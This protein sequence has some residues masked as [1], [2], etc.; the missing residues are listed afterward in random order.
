M[1][2]LIV[3]GILAV[4]LIG[5]GTA[6]YFTQ[7]S[8]TQNTAQETPTTTTSG[9]TTT[10]QPG[11]GT[12]SSTTT[13]TSGEAVDITGAWYGTYTSSQGTGR[14]AWRIWKTGENTYQGVLRTTDPYST[15]TSAVPITIQLNGKQITVGSVAL[16]VTFTGT[17][18]GDAMSGTWQ[19]NN[20]M[21]GGQWSGQRGE[22]DI[23]PEQP[24]TTTPSETTTTTP[25]TGGEYNYDDISEVAPPSTEPYRTITIDLRDTFTQ[26]QG[27]AKL[28]GY[29]QS[30]A[31]GIGH[32][33]LKNPVT[34]ANSTATQIVDILVGK[35]YIEPYP[36]TPV[37][38]TTY[39]IVLGY[40]YGGTPYV[41]QIYVTT[42]DDGHF[43]GFTISIS[44]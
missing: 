36:P 1:N 10:I 5:V 24:S 15:G 35:G 12:T 44:T 21:D 20:G 25:S 14:W 7:L 40:V 34:D 22:T 39:L 42:E 6:V 26:V 16:G 9:T 17:V 18:N 2:T 8:S 31:V 27:G 32:F 28:V 37:N 11:G 4:V 30:G 41:V 23:T 19:M 13:T 38:Q 43:A 33:A 3:V 29:Y